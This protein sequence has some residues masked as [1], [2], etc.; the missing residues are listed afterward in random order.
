MRLTL[1]A[2][3]AYMDEMLEPADAQSLA[4]KIEASPMATDWMHR[5]RDVS[6]RLKLGAPKVS[7]RGLTG[8]ANSVAEYLDHTMSPEN[9][10]EFEKLCLNSDVHLAEV[11][12]AH[13]ILALVLGEPAEVDPKM[14]RRLYAVAEHAEAPA[15]SYDNGR[16]EEPEESHLD[17]SRRDDSHGE[18]HHAE[19]A[20]AVATPH[21]RRPPE[22]PEWLRDQPSSSGRWLPLTIAGLLLIGCGVV[23]W[24]WYT[25]AGRGAQ[26]AG[27]DAPA[28]DPVKNVPAET[29]TV[30][31]PTAA[32]AGAEIADDNES[33]AA[34]NEPRMVI[35]EPSPETTD[36]A[37]AANP[38]GA[39]DREQDLVRD[40]A[41]SSRVPIDGVAAN[42]A[43][44]TEEAAADMPEEG[45]PD[46]FSTAPPVAERRTAL[47]DPTLRPTGA[48]SE[49]AA[50]DAEPAAAIGRLVNEND[51]L[52]RSPGH[53]G[54]WV[55]LSSRDALGADDELIA[56]PTFRPGI[57]LSTGGGAIAHLLGST[58]VRLLA[59]DANEVPGLHVVDGQVIVDTAGK[60]GTQ[61]NLRIGDETYLI[62]FLEADSSVAVDVRRTLPEGGEPAEDTVVTTA[63][64]YVPSGEIEYVSIASKSRQTMKA[65]TTRRLSAA[66]EAD[67][68]ASTES[69]FPAWIHGSP[70]SQVEKW[71]ADALVKGLAV[72]EPVHL[73]LR[74]LAENRR[75]EVRNL[76][77]LSMTLL[78][79]FEA[80]LSVLRDESQKGNWST[81][82]EAV[83]RVLGR[84]P[85]LAAQLKTTLATQ[86][87]AR[88]A[89][90]LYDMLRGYS[91][92]QLQ[93][94]AA[95]QLVGA[96]DHE[97]LDIRVLA[98]W[99][100][101]RVSVGTLGY[102]PE[103]G[104]AKRQQSVRAWRERLDRGQLIPRS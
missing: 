67:A 17:Q 43:A 21:V 88:K 68:D 8:D 80:L 12:S 91:R 31:S 1:R 77:T 102:R 64:L 51:V 73:R 60:P 61:L 58:T 87:E 93:D 65:P 25:G 3:L 53:D 82:I 56:L 50:E 75:V 99:N 97:D 59:P 35:T 7:A 71:A 78:G 54:V 19:D 95:A 86:R 5:I 45:L 83:R 24:L 70:L 23:G 34:T 72:D 41:N 4:E 98:F 74:E 38:A 79:D 14:R 100:L 27:A 32:A 76:A 42:D 26:L 10:T 15:E 104:P 13:Q 90:E 47:N 39:A 16:G 94:G 37:T 40:H 81:Q 6:R 9:V 96:L 22:I 103:A 20:V 52:L 85:E 18:E 33:A 57:A 46:E 11:A 48:P 36:A 49:P 89:H 69:T 101:Q 28:A 44:P 66:V 2:M 63:D 55:R 92:Q 62:T 29:E 30:G 84:N